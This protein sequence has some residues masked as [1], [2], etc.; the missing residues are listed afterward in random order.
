MLHPVRT[1]LM[2]LAL[3]AL[4]SVPSPAGEA[5]PWRMGM[6]TAD[7]LAVLD[8]AERDL[9]AGRRDGAAMTRLLI[10]CA[11]LDLGCR[12]GQLWSPV[13]Y[14]EPD[15]GIHD[16][17]FFPQAGFAFPGWRQRARE[18][19]AAGPLPS[20]PAAAM[21]IRAIDG[22]AA[23]VMA[24]LAGEGRTLPP[25]RAALLRALA[26]GDWRRLDAVPASAL[27]ELQALA[28]LAT[29]RAGP[30]P[31]AEADPGPVPSMMPDAGA[32]WTER[33]CSLADD[34]RTRG[35][36]V[37]G[38]AVA[39]QIQVDRGGNRP[40]LTREICAQALA[41]F[42]PVL[43][44]IAGQA[45]LAPA[46]A[47]FMAALGAPEPAQ[48]DVLR[49]RLAAVDPTAPDLLARAWWLAARI[50]RVAPAPGDRDRT[51]RDLAAQFRYRLFMSGRLAAMQIRESWA[52]TALAHPGEEPLGTGPLA[53]ACA[54]VNR[55]PDAAALQAMEAD[56][57]AERPLIPASAYACHAIR[58]LRSA[59]SA[60]W[61]RGDAIARA[62]R[63]SESPA[64]GPAFD[65]MSCLGVRL[66]GAAAHLRPLIDRAVAGHPWS[67]ARA[68]LRGHL[69]APLIPASAAAAPGTTERVAA[70]EPKV[71][72]QARMVRWEGR[73]RIPVAGTH[74]FRL[75]VSG[76]ARFI[77]PG[78]ADLPAVRFEGDSYG[79]V[80]V[81]AADLPAGDH[82]SCATSS[83]PARASVSPSNGARPVSRSG[84]P[85]PQRSW[86]VPKGPVFGRPAGPPSRAPSRRGPTASASK[87]SCRSRPPRRGM[88]R[89]A[90]WASRMQASRGMTPG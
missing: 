6:G 16:G 33:I 63:R 56:L 34:L 62:W 3:L 2:A 40:E 66:P 15:D 17:G 46:G 41:D 55:Q 82:P 53:L 30:F 13:D 10:A 20:D 8:G 86:P 44:R 36:R 28:L 25:E 12:Q 14:R 48:V 65:A 70:I 42:L 27:T 4:A 75:E 58:A 74:A 29:R 83:C 7:L 51:V 88:R 89:C 45:D 78:H 87:R 71:I 59:D 37:R 26:T 9:A 35:V 49:R 24:W 38:W 21:L 90:P 76:L 31:G 57:T 22:D 50:G 18:I 60:F 84:A 81:I 52:G 61:A 39:M 5:D 67:A 1:L 73:L 69:D 19:L 43:P 68:I 47:A 32:A 80:E 64:D 77:I 23:A 54:A 11:G 85:S 79:L 72:G